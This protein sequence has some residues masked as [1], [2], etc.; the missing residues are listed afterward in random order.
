MLLPRTV[1]P[2]VIVQPLGTDFQVDESQFITLLCEAYGFPTPEVTWLRN[3]TVITV[4][5]ANDDKHTI[6]TEEVNEYYVRSILNISEANPNLDQGEY[7]CRIDNHFIANQPV[8]DSA[9]IQVEGK[10]PP[11][12][13]STTMPLLG[14]FY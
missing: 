6:I 4:E 1:F 5:F 3:T 2:L 14:A 9:N 13:H 11:S 8:I 10:Q 7:K 12:T